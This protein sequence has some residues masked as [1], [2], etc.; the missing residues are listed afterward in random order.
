M[1]GD[2]GS[3]DW[4][5]TCTHISDNSLSAIKLNIIIGIN[6]NLVEVPS[7]I[8]GDVI[9]SIIKFYSSLQ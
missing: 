1:P 7:I 5:R 9:I 2:G 3:D 4:I 6:Y 8:G